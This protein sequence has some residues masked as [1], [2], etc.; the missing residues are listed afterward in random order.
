MT[1]LSFVIPCYRSEKTIGMVIDEIIQTVQQREGYDYEIICVNDGSPDGVYDVLKKI[2]AKN[3]RI[4]VIDLTKNMGKHSAVMA[5]YSVVQGDYIISL[6][7]DYQCP[8]GE[9]WNLLKP[10]E[11]DG[12]DM[13]SAVYRKKMESPWK[14]FGSLMNVK[15]A[16]FIIG[17]PKGISVENFFALKR[18]VVDQVVK[19]PYP[20]PYL[21]GLI[22]RVTHRIQ[23]V[24]MDERERADENPSGF[25]LKKSI[26]L[27]FNG[28]TA[29]SVTP[30][31]LATL[32]GFFFAFLGMLLMIYYIVQKLM[33]PEIIMGYSSIVSILLFSTG[34]IMIMLGIIGE[35]IG[36]IYICI[37]KAPQ[38]VI[39][40]TMNLVK[41]GER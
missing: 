38:Y 3:Q 27:F 39:R 21:S 32:S 9:L 36:R 20:Y 33:H 4:K 28:F 37:N 13:T 31:R 29:F 26:G 19:Y 1:L 18:Y 6:D 5:G 15:M 23:M 40:D 24:E 41:G 14:R 12:Y 7:D 35:Y 2:A 8:M 22:I 11:Q 16:E 34:S 25:T 10:L 30:L 17:R